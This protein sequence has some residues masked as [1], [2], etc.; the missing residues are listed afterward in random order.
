[1]TLPNGITR[2]IAGDYLQIRVHGQWRLKHHL[3]A[4]EKLGRPLVE[5]ERVYFIDGDNRNFDPDNIKVKMT[6]PTS[7][8]VRP[9]NVSTVEQTPDNLWT[10]LVSLT[11][12]YLTINGNKRRNDLLHHLRALDPDSM[13]TTP[14]VYSAKQLWTLIAPLINNYVVMT[15]T[16]GLEDLLDHFSN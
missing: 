12:N 11:D 8:I 4:E 1:M 5:G 3:V 10:L 16:K 7:S 15:G 14:M 2:A 6:Q 13:K 9:Y